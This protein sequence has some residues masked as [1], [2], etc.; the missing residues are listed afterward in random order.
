MT[1][2]L[3]A[4]IVISAGMGVTLYLLIRR[5]RALHTAL[6]VSEARAR[7]IGEFLARFSS[8]IQGEDGVAGAMRSAA[9]HVAE[10]IEAG[11]VVI[12]EVQEE[13]L[14]PVGAWGDY[15]EGGGDVLAEH[16]KRENLVTGH[17]FAG[18]IAQKRT[19]E[20][21]ENAA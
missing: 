9:R 16:L 5:V 6:R 21:V 7:E 15:T 20:L 18:E 11:A 3:T 17:G 19:P 4:L 13:R 2:A 1:I 14:V 8:G 12:Y 10:Q